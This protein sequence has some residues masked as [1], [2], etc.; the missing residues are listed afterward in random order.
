[1]IRYEGFAK[2]YG[3]VLAMDR[4]TLEV[5]AGETLALIGP[6]GSGKSTTLKAA[7]GLVR[8]TAGRVLVE[9]LDV[10]SGPEARAG[11]GYLPQ[12]ISFPE[13]VPAREA[14]R[15]YARLRSAS[16]DEV[17]R[18]LDRVGLSDAA[19]RATDGFSGGMRQRLGIAIALLGRPR[20][21]LLDEPTAAL[22]PTGALQVRDLIAGI[23]AEG[24]TVLLSSHDLAEVDALADRIAILVAGRVIA[25]GTL[26]ELEARAG[27]RGLESVYRRLTDGVVPLPK[28][29]AA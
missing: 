13:G 16:P 17:E 4:L 11:L 8:P 20:I 15:F 23:A 12:R 29:R 3:R 7:V 28:V 22:D 21:L 10:A 9:G 26:A 24:T 2:S 25:A 18:L 1:M 19:D 6:N 14:M 5:P 27:A